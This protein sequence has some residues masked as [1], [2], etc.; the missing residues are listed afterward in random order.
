[1]TRQFTRHVPV[2]ETLE[3][4]TVPANTVPALI[5][6]DVSIFGDTITLNGT[7]A[8]PDADD[9]HTVLID[10]ADGS[11]QSKIAVPTGSRQFQANHSYLTGQAMQLAGRVSIRVT[12]QAFATELIGDLSAF[13]GSAFRDPQAVLGQ[14]TRF[15]SPTSPWGG[16]V[17]PFNA[18]FGGDEILQLNAGEQLI[19][20]F[21]VKVYDN[22]ESQFSGADFLV[23]GNAFYAMDFGTG[24]ATGVIFEE[25]GTIE[26][27]QDGVT[28]YTITAAAADT[29]YPTNGYVNPT[30]PFD[31]P[32][33]QPIESDFGRPVD[34]SFDAAGLSLEQIVAAYNGS[35]GGTAVDIS[36]TG[37]PWIQYVRITGADGGVE[38]D[39]LSIVNPLPDPVTVAEMVARE[40]DETLGLY[41]P[42]A[43]YYEGWAGSSARWLRGEDNA[44]GNPWYF[45][46]EN[47]EFVAWDGSNSATGS[48]LF[49]FD[50]DV[51]LH[52]DRLFAASR[53]A[54][55][56]ADVAQ[57]QLLDEVLGLYVDAGGFYED[58]AGQGVKWL[59]GETNV[60]GN[61]WYFLRDNGEFVAWDGTDMAAAGT[62][63]YT[64]DPTVFLTPELLYEASQ[65]TLSAADALAARQLD[66][67]LGLYRD[68][69]GYFEDWAN[70]GVKWLRG[71]ANVHGNSWYFLRPNGDFVAWNGSDQAEGTVLHTFD[72]LVFLDPKLLHLA[73]QPVLPAAQAIKARELQNTLGLYADSGGY[74]EDWGGFGVK[75]LRGRTN[76][77]GNGWYFIRPTGEL[78]AWDGSDQATGT[79]LYAFDP[80]VFLNPEP[81]L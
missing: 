59:R 50:S 71:E 41:R 44:F 66:G 81:L 45:L 3:D 52:P 57:A 10:W 47:G 68:A 75:W 67:A 63:L 62:V 51:Y 8:D 36:E 55:P 78:V 54:L 34:L 49:R 53:A 39:A 11:P 14:P 42:A 48:V 73:A 70:Q 64:F 30:G 72:P 1:M 76:A 29:A 18:P 6:V 35:G 60:F 40:F 19:V 17:T 38:I 61:P 26:V 77:H 9:S 12:D 23:F 15:T 24:R 28:F 7:F 33:D 32:P 43:G 74:F 16:A 58:W 79:T 69:G 4:R 80:A 27:S 20:K 56:A 5:D 37:L 46:R 65:A 25:P 21:P 2:F 22:P 13:D 31:L